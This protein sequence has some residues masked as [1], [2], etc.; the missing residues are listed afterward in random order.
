VKPTN[1]DDDLGRLIGWRGEHLAAL[2]YTVNLIVNRSLEG[3]HAFTVDVDGYKRRREETLNTLAART[4]EEVRENQ[5]PVDLEPMSAAERR[6][7]HIALADDPDV[8]T[9]SEG[10]GD[11]RHV[12]IVYGEGEEE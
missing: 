12:Q 4:A 2:Q 6:I 1:Q 8:F 11:A 10:E 7:I 5:E 3:R 9:E